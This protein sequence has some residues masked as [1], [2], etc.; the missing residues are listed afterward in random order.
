MRDNKQIISNKVIKIN[1][2]KTKK[3]V[4]MKTGNN[5]KETIIT[6][7]TSNSKTKKASGKKI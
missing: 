4:E 7:P 1:K 5:G 6:T 2:E 3:E